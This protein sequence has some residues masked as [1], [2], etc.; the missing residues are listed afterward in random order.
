MK[1]RRDSAFALSLVLLFIS[2]LVTCVVAL[3]GTAGRGLFS[4]GGFTHRAAAR[5]AA[6]AGLAKALSVLESDPSFQG[7]I[8]ESLEHS[9]SAFEIKFVSANPGRRESYNNLESDTAFDMTEG[10]LPPHSAFVVA[11]GR[12]GTQEIALKALVKEAEETMSLSLLGSRRI[13]LFNNVSVR[14][15]ESFTT[16]VERPSGVHSNLTDSGVSVS[17][18]GPDPG[19][20]LTASGVVST[21]SDDPNSLS[22]L[23][24]SGVSVGGTAANAPVR[25]HF[26]IDIK[27]MVALRSS[28]PGPTFPGFGGMTLPPGDHYYSND[29]VLM[30]DLVLED[31]AR[32]F[33]DGDLTINGSV[34]GVGSIAVTGFTALKGDAHVSTADGDY[35]ALLSRGGVELTGFD[36][37]AYLD[38]LAGTDPVAAVHWPRVRQSFSGM[39]S[40]VDPGTDSWVGENVDEPF[41]DARGA[42]GNPGGSAQLLAATLPNGPT[43]EFL[44]RK[45]EYMR[46]FY[47][48]AWYTVDGAHVSD[49]ASVDQTSS[50]SK[51][52]HGLAVS[53]DYLAGG[54]RA[55][56]GGVADVVSSQ[57]VGPGQTYPSIGDLP[58]EIQESIQRVVAA[59]QVESVD[60]LGTSFFKGFIYTNGPLFVGNEVTVVGALESQGLGSVAGR[61]IGSVELEP[62]D[63]YLGPRSDLLYVADL[64]RS[65]LPL[66]RSGLL[67]SSFVVEE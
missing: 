1:F 25:P 51:L 53:Q 32:I 19:D 55:D 35:I 47:H 18:T 4:A 15:I 30:G 7:S 6:E 9:G 38:A 24:A 5:Q 13:S 42:L 21:S 20:T 45:F 2:V 16:N 40:E 50:A 37:T 34:R 36:G 46:L 26:N 11:I 52:Q 59:V 57:D 65:N 41:D 17:W 28:L 33:V 22:F 31:G 3:L 64:F 44:K 48:D 66:G 10:L 23:P 39:Q 49:P 58:L 27:E 56:R 14:G 61:T 67:K 43:P 54:L 12:C 63:I 29:Q 60:K 8:E 62:G